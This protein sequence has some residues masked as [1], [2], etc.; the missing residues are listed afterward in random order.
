VKNPNKH[1]DYPIVFNGADIKVDFNFYGGFNPTR[2]HPGDDDEIELLSI[3]NDRGESLPVPATQDDGG[4]GDA[5]KLHSIL[6][7][8]LIEETEI[9]MSTIAIEPWD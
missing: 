2:H 1:T 7:D 8:S 3:R 9:A 5:E 6:L 4:N